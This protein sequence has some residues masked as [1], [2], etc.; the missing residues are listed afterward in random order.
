VL[1]LRLESGR[2]YSL[3]VDSQEQP[4]LSDNSDLGQKQRPGASGHRFGPNLQCSECGVTWDAH[5][6]E[7]SPCLKLAADDACAAPERLDGSV[8]AGVGGDEPGE[9]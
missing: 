5:Q 7:P 4:G 2:L 1:R 8:A 6:L 3:L 9:I